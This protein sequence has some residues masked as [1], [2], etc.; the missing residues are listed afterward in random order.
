[1]TRLV[2]LSDWLPPD[3]GAVGQY[4]A[5]AARERA[6]AGD[7][8]VLVGLSSTAD[9]VSEE[10]PGGLL[11]T[12]R[13][14]RPTYDRGRLL[15]RAAWTLVTNVALLWH[16][17]GPL[18]AAD[19]I[20]FT[21]SPPFLIYFIVPLKTLFWR[22]ARVTYRITDFYP[23]CLLAAYPR[24]H[25]PLGLLRRMTVALRRRLQRLEVLGADQKARLLENGIAEDRIAVVPNASPVAITTET[26]PLERP[27]ELRDRPL[28]LYSGNFGVAHDE[29]TF[30]DAYRRHHAGGR[31]RV[32]LWLNAV[33]HKA[34]SLEASLRA[35][36]LPVHRSALVPLSQLDR[37]LVTPTAHLITLRDEFVG[38]VLPSKVYGCVASGR[39]VLF[40]GSR[41]SDVH[42]V[43][44]DGVPAGRYWQ[45][46]VGDVNAVVLALD[47]IAVL[48]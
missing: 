18:R 32:A 14:R 4:A 12:I 29:Q 25:R 3:F 40:I 45:A 16:A 28:L 13:V 46:D 47:A 22:R 43:C 23:E 34:D 9:S 5:L 6:R 20:V 41:G 24:L 37:L 19:E 7:D 31:G 8:V 15:P 48:V 44:H 27:P 17:R 30:L 21:A 1:M 38:Y 35:E 33:G 10:R 42:L 39:P 2:Y 11:R 36:G 26:R